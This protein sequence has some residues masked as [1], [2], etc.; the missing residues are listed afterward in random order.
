MP[1]G[2]ATIQNDL[3]V[4]N[5]TTLTGTLDV[6]GKT[7]LV[8]VSMTNLS[9]T[10][11]EATMCTLG[12]D[13]IKLK[14]N[15]TGNTLGFF[16]TTPITKPTPTATPATLSYP[17]GAQPIYNDT[18]FSASGSSSQYTLPQIVQILYNIGLLT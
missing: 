2:D 15:S 13:T 6:T 5:N 3:K 9:V 12:G 10:S 18:T 17:G 16:G 11:V 4:Q 1:A 14:K 8:D 7:T